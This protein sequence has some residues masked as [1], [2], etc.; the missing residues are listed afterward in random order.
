MGSRLFNAVLSIVMKEGR[1]AAAGGGLHFTCLFNSKGPRTVL[2]RAG[3]RSISTERA[4]PEISRRLI[5]S[6][7]Q[8]TSP[9]GL[10]ANLR[11]VFLG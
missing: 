5:L 9:A 3:D 11:N 10:L 1:Q 2:Q 4:F 8:D 6:D 7:Q